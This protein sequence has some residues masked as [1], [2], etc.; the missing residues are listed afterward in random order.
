[1][2]NKKE[3]IDFFNK[4]A[5]N[6]DLK[7]K[8]QT[9]Q[10]IKK[11]LSNIKLKNYENVCDVG[12]GTGILYPYL[13]KLF[14]NYTGIDFAYEMIKIAKEKF[15]Q[16]KFITGD[17]DNHRFKKNFF[18]LVIIFNAF[19]HFENRITTILKANKIL[20]KQGKII[21]AHSFKLNKINK[22]HKETENKIIKKHIIT[23]KEL[24]E[25]FKKSNFKKIKIIHN[26][27]FYIE[28]TK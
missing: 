5:H 1:M 20:K 22:I 25:L 26:D 17:F 7:E 6:W 24:K 3:I 12:C 15:P 16:A 4:N 11:I 18:D 9:H 2:K 27:Y 21:I 13:S 28:G 8:P 23:E 19:P 14:K 10:K